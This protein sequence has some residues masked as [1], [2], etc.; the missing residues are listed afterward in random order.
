MMA[1]NFSLGVMVA[2]LVA[3]SLAGQEMLP[4]GDLE[5]PRFQAA[6]SQQMLQ[7]GLGLQLDR[8]LQEPGRTATADLFLFNSS[9]QTLRARSP[10]LS[11]PD[12]CQF[13]WWIEDFQTRRFVSRVTGAC[14]TAPWEEIDL[15]QGTFLRWTLDVPMSYR[16][17]ETL[18][19]NGTP[20]PGGIYRLVGQVRMVVPLSPGGFGPSLTYTP[21]ANL[22]FHVVVCDE[23]SEPL[24]MR[25]LGRGTGSGYPVPARAGRSE[26]RVLVTLRTEEAAQGF[27][28]EHTR[29]MDPKP[30]PPAV[31]FDEEMVLVLISSRPPATSTPG[32]RFL[33]VSENP[34]ELVAAVQDATDF[35]AEGDPDAGTWAAVA[36]PRSQ[37]AVEYEV[38]Q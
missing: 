5:A 11:E 30:S 8:P 18:D 14:S 32:L 20:L 26:D 19:P 9:S 17:S 35:E 10:D 23:T 28:T 16:R 34:C 13:L 24:A 2:L 36:V 33:S 4:D 37:K 12:H 6:P 38:A 21:F 1:N 25:P 29:G 27:W 7:Y 31:N 3:P 15:P 22:P